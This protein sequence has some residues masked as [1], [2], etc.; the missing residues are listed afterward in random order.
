LKSYECVA[1]TSVS[2]QTLIKIWPRKGVRFMQKF[3]SSMFEGLT[4]PGY[5]IG[6]LGEMM[7]RCENSRSIKCCDSECSKCLF[8]YEDKNKHPI[9]RKWM[10]VKKERSQ[11]KDS[12][13]LLLTTAN[14][15][16]EPAQIADQCTCNLMDG[17]KKCAYC[18]SQL[19]SSLES[20]L[21]G[22]MPKE[23]SQE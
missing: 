8:N 16:E 21:M 13:K 17:G 7:A 18:L 1:V 11:I 10:R 23:S 12:A 5:S 3:E 4:V 6:T 2:R 20:L 19:E 9:F 14:R 15:Q 22:G